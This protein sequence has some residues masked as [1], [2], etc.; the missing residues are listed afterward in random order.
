MTKTLACCLVV[1]AVGCSEHGESPPACTAVDMNVTGTE[2]TTTQVDLGFGGG[3]SCVQVLITSAAELDTQFG[4]SPPSELAA[5]DFTVDRI[6]LGSS[7]PIVQF[8]VDD[9]TDVVV[10]QEP[11]CQGIAPSCVAYVLHGTTRDSVSVIDCPYRG[12]DPCL[13]P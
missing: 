7:N 5:V 11:L 8:A 1:V 3:G 13:A 2:L 12:P 4:G 10:G 9:G 6:F